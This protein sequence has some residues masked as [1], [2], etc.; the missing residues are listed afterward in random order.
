M[1]NSIGYANPAAINFGTLTLETLRNTDSDRAA[2][3]RLIEQR[4]PAEEHAELRAMLGI[5][6]PRPQEV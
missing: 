4:A 3:R 2:A 5:E 6:L 1:T